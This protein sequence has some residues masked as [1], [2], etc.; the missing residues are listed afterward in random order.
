MRKVTIDKNND[1]STTGKRI[2]YEREQ[3]G[4]SQQELADILI[5]KREKINY[6][7]KG[8]RSLNI[9]ELETIANTFNVSTDYL[10]C[11]IEI[12]SLDEKTIEIHKE[13]NLSEDAINHLRDFKNYMIT[14]KQVKLIDMEPDFLLDTLDIFLSSGQFYFLIIAMAEYLKISNKSKAIEN[15]SSYDFSNIRPTKD[16]SFPHELSNY[17]RSLDD[18]D[19]QIY[20]V[21]KQILD[22]VKDMAENKKI[23]EREN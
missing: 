20:R 7:E 17:Y 13:L 18:Q 4:M 1:L 23:E 15:N 12:K 19:V 5:V 9:Q 8:T 14:Y 2:K 22:I 16:G 10:L 3:V 6:I 21:Q 11:R